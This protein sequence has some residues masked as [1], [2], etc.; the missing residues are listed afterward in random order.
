MT[1]SVDE[2]N[3]VIP[4]YVTVTGGDTDSLT[5]S[6]ESTDRSH[7]GTTTVDVL[8]NSVEYSHTAIAYTTLSFILVDPCLTTVFETTATLADMTTT[9]L[10]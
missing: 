9:V 1:F 8:A 5:V 6:A 3:N 10:R 4:D 7:V 2:I